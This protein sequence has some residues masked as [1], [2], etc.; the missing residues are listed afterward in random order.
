[1]PEGA[2]TTKKIAVPAS[3]TSV[4]ASAMISTAVT[5]G[6]SPLPA[7]PEADDVLTR[8]D[9]RRVSRSDVGDF[10]HFVGLFAARCAHLY[11]ITLFFANK[12]ASN[13]RFYVEQAF[14]DARLVFTHDA[15]GLFLVGVLIDQRNCGAELDRP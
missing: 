15:I 2:S 14:F 4:N 12:R 13:G 6:R 3:H 7:R 9:M 5:R 1:M 11:A 8:S 10:Q